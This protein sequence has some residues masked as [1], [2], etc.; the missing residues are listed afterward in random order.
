[1]PSFD[2]LVESWETQCNLLG[3]RLSSLTSSTHGPMPTAAAHLSQN[4]LSSRTH[5]RNQQSLASEDLPSRKL[6]DRLISAGWSQ[7]AHGPSLTNCVNNS[8]SLAI[9][10]HELLAVLLFLSGAIKTASDHSETN[11]KLG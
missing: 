1:M 3:V 11:S 6:G 5:G 10:G 7:I 9:A 8:V 4:G 2:S